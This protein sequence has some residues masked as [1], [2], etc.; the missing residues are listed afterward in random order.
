MGEGLSSS[1]G[2]VNVVRV[3]TV[4]AVLMEPCVATGVSSHIDIIVV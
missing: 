2:A 3:A 4:G 1:G